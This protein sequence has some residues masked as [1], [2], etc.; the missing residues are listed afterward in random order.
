MIVE[1]NTNKI[2]DEMSFLDFENWQEIKF[3]GLEN[4]IEELDETNAILRGTIEETGEEFESKLSLEDYFEGK[5][6][7]LNK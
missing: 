6:F 4:C 5:H 1:P 3:I 2:M 7:V